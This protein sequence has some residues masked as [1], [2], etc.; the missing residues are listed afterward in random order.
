MLT[1]T[2]REYFLYLVQQDQKRK[3]QDKLEAL[4]REGIDSASFGSDSRLLAKFAGI[5]LESE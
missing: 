2:G 1:I 3:A 5:S 4:L